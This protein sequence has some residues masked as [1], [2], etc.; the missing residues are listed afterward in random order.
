[1]CSEGE[2]VSGTLL[3]LAGRRA[4]SFARV[5]FSVTLFVGILYSYPN[6][7]CRRF[8]PGGPWTDE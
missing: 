8:G 1:M 2:E 5:V 4:G 7:I 3:V 6:E